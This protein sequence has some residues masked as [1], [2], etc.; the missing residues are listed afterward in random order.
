MAIK[1]M[2]LPHFCE[3]GIQAQLRDEIQARRMV[4]KSMVDPL[5][6]N[7][8]SHYTRLRMLFRQGPRWAVSYGFSVVGIVMEYAPLGTLFNVMIK[9][10][11]LNGM[12]LKYVQQVAIQVYAYFSNAVH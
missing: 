10:Q 3:R 9:N 8:Q 4:V 12:P 2:F 5:A 7:S 6:L 11:W 1:V